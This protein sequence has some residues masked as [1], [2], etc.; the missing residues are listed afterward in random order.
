MVFLAKMDGYQKL[1]DTDKNVTK[2]GVIIKGIYYILKN[3]CKAK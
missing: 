3:D 1:C 2:M